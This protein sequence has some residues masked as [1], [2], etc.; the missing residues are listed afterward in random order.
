MVVELLGFFFD[1]GFSRA[2]NSLSLMVERNPPNTFAL[3]EGHAGSVDLPTGYND[4]RYW[5][6][7]S[8]LNTQRLPGL[9]PLMVPRCAR[10]RTVTLCIL[11][12]SAASCKL[13]VSFTLRY[14]PLYEPRSL[15]QILDGVTFLVSSPDVFH[16]CT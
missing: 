13:S 2:S 4:S 7:S 10:R 9:A 15:L 5:T 14:L 8:R 11:R 6:S 1:V 12:K 3:I 16:R